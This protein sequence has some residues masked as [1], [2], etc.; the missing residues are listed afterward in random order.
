MNVMDMLRLDGKV[1][2]ITGTS[3]PIGIGARVGEGFAEAG[4]TVVLASRKVP[5]KIAQDISERTGQKVLA[6]HVD[7]SEE[8]SVKN[9][10]EE[11]VGD[12]GKIDILVNNAGIGY[13]GRTSTMCID[14]E[15]QWMNVLDINMNGTLRCTKHVVKH[16]IENGIRGSI[17]N[18]SSM[19]GIRPKSP[20][21]NHS[22][23]TSKAAINM[24]TA[25]WSGELAKYGI[26]V[27][28]VCPGFFFTDITEGWRKYPD[29][30]QWLM[31]KVP[32]GEM[33]STE[34]LKGVYLY[35][36]SDASSFT[37]GALMPVDGGVTASLIYDKAMQPDGR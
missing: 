31:N 37:T 21:G 23:S 33:P 36:A 10:V 6:K 11:T 7:V 26:R 9:L 35:L 22:Y 18:T 32:F 15:R 16:M 5:E 29:G 2:L 17:I 1:A 13:K 24:L 19:S 12:A 14:I 8:E 3:S 30:G 25:A 34:K 28:A 27:N 4:C 20:E